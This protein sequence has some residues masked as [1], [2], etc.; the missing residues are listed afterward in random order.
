M[1]LLHVLDADAGGDVPAD[2]VEL[3][4]RV[5]GCLWC[6]DREGGTLFIASRRAGVHEL[7]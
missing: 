5:S 7:R 4:Q 2:L 1:Q 6:G 3:M